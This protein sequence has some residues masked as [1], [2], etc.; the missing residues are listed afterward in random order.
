MA[1]AKTIKAKL[2]EA[3][4]R[5]KAVQEAAKRGAVVRRAASAEEGLESRSF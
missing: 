3:I 1:D 5:Q 4:E 2:A